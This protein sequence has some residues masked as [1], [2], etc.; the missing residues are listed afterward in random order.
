MRVTD[1]IKRLK[2]AAARLNAEI[3]ATQTELASTKITNEPICP[4]CGAKRE[5]KNQFGG[6]TFYES[7]ICL[8]FKKAQEKLLEVH[9]KQSDMRTEYE[10]ILNQISR[11]ENTA[12]KL[13]EKSNLGRRF[14]ERTFETFNAGIFPNA[15]RKART[16]AEMF[17]ENDGQGIMFIG[18]VGT[19]K[20]HLA[21]AITNYIISEF[22][23]PVRFITAVELFGMLRDFEN[24]KNAIDEFKNI[25]LLAIDDLG[26]EKVTEWNREKLFEIVNHRYENYL[27]IV[28]TTN[29]SPRELEQI[30]GEAVF[31]RLCEVCDGIR[32]EGKDHRR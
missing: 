14:K 9:S 6:I 32:M 23:I 30:L 20:T 26:K 1:E 17:E 2:K 11:Y 29:G 13:L 25:P 4:F 18:S 16:Y 8:E 31:S 24:N 15:Y 22:A 27:P 19:G 7:C 12:K 3:T 10:F 28:I 21:A 5:V